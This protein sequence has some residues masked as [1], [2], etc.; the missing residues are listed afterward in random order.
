MKEDFGVKD[1]AEGEEYDDLEKANISKMDGLFET[2]SETSNK[3]A[4][5]YKCA[6]C[7]KMYID[8]TELI[9]HVELWDVEENKESEEDREKVSC[10]YCQTLFSN[11]KEVLKHMEVH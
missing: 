4:E 10:P 2:E 9:E 11:S 3:E 5:N 8:N 6:I 1:D 7:Q